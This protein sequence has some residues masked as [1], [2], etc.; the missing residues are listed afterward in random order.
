MGGL[1][2]RGPVGYVWDPTP[3]DAKGQRI[4]QLGLVGGNASMSARRR[5]HHVGVNRRAE[6]PR[7]VR[8][9]GATIGALAW[10]EDKRRVPEIC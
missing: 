10:L 4:S 2:T 8:A 7:T 9:L 5:L 3:N 1:A 6:L